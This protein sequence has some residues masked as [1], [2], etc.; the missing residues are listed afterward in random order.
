MRR[1]L[2][3]DRSD[4]TTQ[5]RRAKRDEPDFRPATAEISRAQL[6]QWLRHGAGLSNGRRA[7]EDL[8]LEYRAGEV[9]KLL[10]SSG[11]GGPGMLDK[12]VDLLDS[13]VTAP[14]FA[15]FLTVP[16]LRYLD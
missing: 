1:Q 13:L 8:Y 4:R 11:K 7:T 9:S 15:E 6:W 16:G 2:G 10:E 3:A 5:R 14:T 12:A